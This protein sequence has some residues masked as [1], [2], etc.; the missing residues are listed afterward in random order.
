MSVLAILFVTGSISASRIPTDVDHLL[1]KFNDELR[2]YRHYGAE[3]A[4]DMSINM[5]HEVLGM[6]YI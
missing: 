5:T 2:L 4:W 6:Q 1:G 3:L